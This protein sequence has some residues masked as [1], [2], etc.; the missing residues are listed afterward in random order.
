MGGCSEHVNERIGSLV[1]LMGHRVAMIRSC[2][3]VL[4]L[5]LLLCSVVPVEQF[6]WAVESTCGSTGGTGHEQAC[7]FSDNSAA[8]ES[9]GDSPQET[10]D[11]Y[12]AS[13][14]SVP[15]CRSNRLH[16][17]MNKIPS[18]ALLV[19]RLLHPPTPLS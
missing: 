17:S 6:G 13:G 10:P 3:S 2:F 9:Q 8:A 19:S 16:A 4:V 1:E 15:D 7:G 18:P 12:V 14:V 5:T 11:E